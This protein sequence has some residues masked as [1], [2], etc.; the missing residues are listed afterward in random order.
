MTAKSS[1]RGTTGTAFFKSPPRRTTGTAL[2]KPSTGRTTGTSLFKAPTGRTTGTALFKSPTGRTTGTALFKPPAGRLTTRS[3]IFNLP[4]GPALVKLP[5][6]RATRT[7]VFK[8]LAGRRTTRSNIFKLPTGCGTPVFKPP[9]RSN[10]RSIIFKLPLLGGRPSTLHLSL[11]HTLL[12]HWIRRDGVSMGHLIRG[13]EVS[14]LPFLQIFV[15]I[16]LFSG[17]FCGVSKLFYLMGLKAPGFSLGQPIQPNWPN[18]HPFQSKDLVAHLGKHSA[19]FP[20][21]ALGKDHLQPSALPLRFHHLDMAGAG[22]AI[23]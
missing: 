9:A 23:A 8:L 18:R 12:G 19:D 1:P 17:R 16:M 14:G 6:G 7:S 21:L 10:S 11:S 2:F 3:N 22:L 20:V 4:T 15:A 5:T 13:G